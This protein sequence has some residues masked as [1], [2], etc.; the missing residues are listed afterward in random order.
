MSGTITTIFGTITMNITY[1]SSPNTANFN[2]STGVTNTFT[3]T[4]TSITDNN[5]NILPLQVTSPSP[6]PSSDPCVGI[7]PSSS[8]WCGCHPASTLC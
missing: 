8:D 7:D 6:S 5:G 2:F 4:N 1:P 3:F